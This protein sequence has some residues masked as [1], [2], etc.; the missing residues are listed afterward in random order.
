MSLSFEFSSGPTKTNR[1]NSI[2]EVLDQL[3]NN[4]SK[5]ISPKEVRDAF[6]TSWSNSIFKITYPD[7][8]VNNPYIGIDTNNPSDRDFKHKILL[9]KRSLSSQD[10]MNPT[11]LGT[12]TDIFFY[13]TK[14]DTDPNNDS[15]KL[16]IL[17][18]DDSNYYTSAPYIESKKTGTEIDLN[19]NNPNGDININSVTGRISVNNV[20][21]PT[22]S[23]NASDIA[24]GKVLRYIGS[25][26]NGKFEWVIPAVTTTNIGSSGGTTTITGSPVTL[27]G[28]N[29]E[30]VEDT[31][32]P[33]TIGGVDI[34]DNFESGSFN[35]TA[36]GLNDGDDWPMT[37]VIRK[38]LYPYVQPEF[39][40][41][42]SNFTLGDIYAEVGVNTN[43]VVSYDVTIFS[44]DVEFEINTTGGTIPALVEDG[45][46]D[47][48]S[49]ANR[50]SYTSINPGSNK[51]GSVS[52]SAERS[53]RGD[54]KFKLT[55][56]EI[57]TVIPVIT[58]QP[59]P[60]PT[61]VYE[62][63]VSIQFVDPIYYGMSIVDINGVVSFTDFVLN[64]A[65]K[66]IKPY[67]NDKYYEVDYGGV[68][69]GSPVD[70]YLYF[71][72]PNNGD[73]PG[74]ISEIKDHNGFVL[75]DANSLPLSSF[76]SSTL[77]RD[78]SGSPYSLNYIVYKTKLP[79]TLDGPSTFKFKF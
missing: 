71:A 69:S 78:T 1:L 28:Y 34:G 48:Y 2:D 4:T 41:S 24:D 11:L 63:E 40:I 23:E 7:S 35:E 47:D 46:L 50:P 19:I 10:V 43:I 38:L 55:V 29:L 58:I 75:H 44:Y 22:L 36:S 3:A 30:F 57:P 9:G 54:V 79:T 56:T 18:G 33:K 77:S 27:N 73:F 5:L 76:D 49:I 62:K 16:S 74:A 17:A 6:L 64:D 42:V 60:H 45:E 61:T 52:E 70:G 32:V 14:D 20:N 26:P 21:F 12:D 53:T 66:L 15:T 8:Y 68:I 72:Y 13:N 51:N 65:S 25:Y 31:L 39:D 67:Y 37:G 59:I